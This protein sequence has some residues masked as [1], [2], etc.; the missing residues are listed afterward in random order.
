MQTAQGMDWG[1]VPAWFSAI[2]SG[3]SVLLALYIIL[4]DRKKAEREDAM[5]VICWRDSSDEERTTHVR[6]AAGRAIHHVRMLGWLRPNGGG[7]AED[8][9][10][11]GWGIAGLLHPDEDAEVTTLY[12]LGDRKIVHWAVQFTDADGRQWVRELNSGRLAEQVSQRRKA[13]WRR[14]VRREVRH[15]RAMWRQVRGYGR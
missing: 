7:T 10:F 4:R 15:R 11:E 5:K 2:L 13:L 9:G 1:T 8:V 6:N 14:A 3:G 12:R